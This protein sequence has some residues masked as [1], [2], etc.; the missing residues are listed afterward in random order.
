MKFNEL[1]NGVKFVC[2]NELFE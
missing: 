2:F 1:G